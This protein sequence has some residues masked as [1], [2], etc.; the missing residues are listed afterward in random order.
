MQYNRGVTIYPN[1]TMF[2]ASADLSHT[3]TYICIANNSFRTI[4]ESVVLHVYAHPSCRDIKSRQ[5]DLSGGAIKDTSGF[6]IIDPDGE[7][8]G[9][10]P[11]QVF[12]NM[13]KYVDN[14]VTVISHDSEDRTL[15]NGFE[16]SGSYKRAVSYTGASLTQI[17]NLISV[18]VECRQFIKYE[19]LEAE[20][21]LRNGSWWVSRDGNRMNY[22]GGAVPNSGTCA[23]A[24]D[25]SCVNPDFG[26]NCDAEIQNEWLEDSGFLSDKSTLPVTQLRFGDTGES[27]EQGYHTLGKLMCIG[28]A[29]DI[30]P[31]VTVSISTISIMAITSTETITT[32]TASVPTEPLQMVTAFLSASTE[33]VI[34]T[35][36]ASTATV[37]ASTS[38]AA[39][40][41][42]GSKSNL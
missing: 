40:A 3:G 14:A 12:C 9:E 25:N 27:S 29:I 33:S 37:I 5:L 30:P 32:T 21:F 10:A 36:T 38:L 42:S 22:W 23:C 35:I 15:V 28:E 26:C 34:T 11:F 41:G 6:Y 13:T 1:N 31:P 7:G 17:E 20:L 16:S 19:C 24:N 2:I 18:S 8:K 39:A 4:T